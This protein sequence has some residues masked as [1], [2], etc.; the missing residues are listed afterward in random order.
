MSCTRRLRVDHAVQR[1][2]AR[3]ARDAG[4]TAEV[5]PYT[6]YGSTSWVRVLGSRAAGKGISSATPR[7]RPEH[8]AGAISSAFRLRTR[9]YVSIFGER[10]HEIQ[11]DR[12]GIIDVVVDVDLEPGWHRIGLSSEDSTGRDG[13]GLH[14]RSADD[15][16]GRVRH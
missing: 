8:A 7:H 16:R 6:G 11:A 15:V 14:R 3:R 4:Y 10:S 12:S 1:W 13:P 2:R 9:R 5:T